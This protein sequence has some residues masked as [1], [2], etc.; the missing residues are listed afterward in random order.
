MKK[1]LKIQTDDEKLQQ[2]DFAK[3]LGVYFDNNPKLEKHI[4]T[5]QISRYIKNWSVARNFL[6]QG[7][8][9]IIR[10]QIFCSCESQS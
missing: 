7:R 3:Y 5:W 2:K 8:F 4:E 6:G 10:A 9:L 1:K